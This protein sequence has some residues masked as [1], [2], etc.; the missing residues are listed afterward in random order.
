ML[1]LPQ[2]GAPSPAVTGPGCRTCALTKGGE[3]G[4][5]DGVRLDGT[6]NLPS[7]MPYHASQMYSRNI[8]SL[9][10]LM[11]TKE[12]KL[13][14]DMNDDVIKGTVITKDGEVVHEQTKKAVGEKVPA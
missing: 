10:A 13:N 6:T 12:G 3:G 14:L 11:I 8:A 7:T 9:L 1:V 4:A 5:V 2:A